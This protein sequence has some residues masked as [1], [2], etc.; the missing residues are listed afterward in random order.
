M[1]ALRYLLAY[2]VLA[3]LSINALGAGITSKLQVHVSYSDYWMWKE[4]ENDMLGEKMG[5]CDAVACTQSLLTNVVSP[6]IDPQ[7]TCQGGW[8][9]AS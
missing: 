8:I 9:R 6:F 3:L 4:T 1:T 7:L 5:M 2:A